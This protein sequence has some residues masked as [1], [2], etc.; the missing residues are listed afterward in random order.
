MYCLCWSDIIRFGH[1]CNKLKIEKYM[2]T[3]VSD[4]TPDI[5]MSIQSKINVSSVQSVQERP[6]RNWT[7]FNGSLIESEKSD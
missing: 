7:S 6:A 1:W 2:M 5:T 3:R 4:G